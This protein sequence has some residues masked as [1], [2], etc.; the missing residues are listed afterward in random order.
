MKTRMRCNLSSKSSIKSLVKTEL[1]EELNRDKSNWFPR[2]D[3]PEHKAYDKRTPG[4]LKVEWEGYGIK[5]ICSKT[6]YCWGSKD[7]FSWKGVNK[8]TNEINKDKYINVLLTKQSG[9][10]RNMGFRVMNHSMYTYAQVRDAFCFFYPKRKVLEDGV[11]TIPLDVWVGSLN[12]KIA[13]IIDLGYWF[14]TCK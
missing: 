4:L 12:M 14:V 9:S 11:S 2:T 8:R 6:Y 7:K 3:T 10:G 13:W 5:E 1:K